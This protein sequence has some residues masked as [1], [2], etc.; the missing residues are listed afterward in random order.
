[1]QFLDTKIVK[2]NNNTLGNNNILRY[3]NILINNFI[4]LN[5]CF[6]NI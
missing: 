2:N 6:Y 3:N 4:L 5:K 1:M